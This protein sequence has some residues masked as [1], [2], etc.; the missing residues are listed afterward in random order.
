M[1]GMT[2]AMLMW[3]FDRVPWMRVIECTS[4]EPELER[5]IVQSVSERDHQ[6]VQEVVNGILF[7]TKTVGG[8]IVPMPAIGIQCRLRP[9]VA[10]LGC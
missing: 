1:C 2:T 10:Q 8:F 3:L 4:H 7:P 6:M 5:P 9:H